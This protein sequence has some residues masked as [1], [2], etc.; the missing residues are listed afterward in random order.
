MVRWLI[1]GPQKLTFD[2]PVDRL[3]VRLV[4]GRINVVGA[5][6][7]ARLEVT[8]ISRF[9]VHV[10]HRDGRLAI[11]HERQ[12]RWATLLWPLIQSSRRFRTEISVAVPVGTRLDLDL[13]SGSVIVT[14]IGGAAD[15]DVT[16]GYVTLMGLGG[17]VSARVLSGSVEVLGA[18]GD[19]TVET[20]SG[21]VI[22]ADS[23]AG[24]VDASTV[25]GAITCDLDN[26][27]DSAIRLGTISGN[28]T[29]RIREDSDLTVRLRTTSG[30]ITSAFPQ[31]VPVTGLRA[32][33]SCDGVLGTGLGRLDAIAVSGSVAL[34]SRVVDDD[35][36]DHVPADDGAFA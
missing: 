2:E 33:Q 9:P 16:S 3:A 36:V 11:R 8:R 34:L 7:P 27:R 35:P 32:G 5:D 23:S 14:G 26:P 20:V 4:S 15:V 31:L 12:R 17:P 18:S 1:D 24:R 13:V 10:E 6:G 25:S 30:R 19:L 22:I 28:V 29:V 21:E